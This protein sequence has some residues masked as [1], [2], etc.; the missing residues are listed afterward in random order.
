[1]ETIL[2][3]EQ[4]VGIRQ[5]VLSAY[6]VPELSELAKLLEIPYQTLQHYFIGRTPLPTDL[7]LRLSKDTHVSI[8]W[9]LMGEGEKYPGVNQTQ[10]QKLGDQLAE[11]RERQRDIFD[12][13]A[14][15]NELPDQ[16]KV[17]LSNKIVGLVANYL[18]NAC[19]IRD[20]EPERIKLIPGLAV[21]INEA[22]A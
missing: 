1:M 14:Q 17:A 4:L 20:T 9:I 8:H 18:L 10:S 3:P 12:L 21:D 16:V 13:V 11:R 5:R 15:F 6:N 19:D 22:E 7:L 2:S